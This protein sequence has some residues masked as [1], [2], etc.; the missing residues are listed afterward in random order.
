MSSDAFFFYNAIFTLY[1]IIYFI[2]FRCLSFSWRSPKPL[3]RRACGTGKKSP[4]ASSCLA[5]VRSEDEEKKIF[6]FEKTLL[7]DV[8]F[9]S[10]SS[11]FL[12]SLFFPLFFPP[13]S[14]HGYG[15]NRKL[16]A[17]FAINR[18]FF[19]CFLSLSLSLSPSPSSSFSHYF[20]PCLH[21]PCIIYI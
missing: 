12:C 5:A 2:V 7:S 13:F 17:H 14:E 9:F 18:D 16:F 8:C 3:L 19:I 1:S 4:R 20:R 15:Y 6:F 11:S 10:L 21:C